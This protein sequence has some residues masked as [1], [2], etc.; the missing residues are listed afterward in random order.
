[1]NILIV[2]AGVSGIF[3]SIFLKSKN[4]NL[5]VLLFDK[6]NIIGKKL[7]AT[8]NGRCNIG[9]KIVNDYSYNDLKI[10]KLM[11]EFSLKEEELLNE[12]GI[13]LRNLNNLMYPNSLSS[14]TLNNY[15]LNL[16]NKY[17]VELHL[18]E[19][20][21]EY[22]DK[23]LI[24]S[25]NKYNYD[26]LIFST[27]AKSMKSSGSDGKIFNLLKKHN[28]KINELKPGLAPITLKENVK[29]L[30]NLRL[31]GLIKLVSNNHKIYE[32]NGEVIFK[33]DGISGISIFNINSIINRNNIKDSKISLDLFPDTKED[34]LFSKI[35]NK[36]KV[37]GDI[38][39]ESLFG[40]Q[41]HNYIK[42]QS[43]SNLKLYVHLLKNLEFNYKS[44]YDFDFSQVTLGGISLEEVNDNFSSKKEKNIYFIGE[45]LD[46]DGLCGGYNIMFAIFS[47][48]I[49]SNSITQSL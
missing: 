11:K 36:Y 5:N 13:F 45:V 10:S 44:S 30:E 34:D 31:K 6:N 1:M 7:L 23:K 3:L 18:N 29:E 39:L 33:K 19:E 37:F 21:I 22:N 14:K 42:K 43:H 24:S 16:L 8:G 49:V 25:L 20:V 15:L 48:F 26:K 27:G 28:Y 47:A 46:V 17:N 40:K 2:G 38:F 9:N 12:Y 4:K 35:N 41:L 32:E